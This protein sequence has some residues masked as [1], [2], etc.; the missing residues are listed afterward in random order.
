MK[1]N[2][3]PNCS[4]WMLSTFKNYIRLIKE[5]HDG[6]LAEWKSTF[7]VILYHYRQITNFE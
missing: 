5:K 2:K 7:I 6:D 1:I 3:L 4:D